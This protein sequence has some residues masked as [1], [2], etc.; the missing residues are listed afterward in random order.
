MEQDDII[1]LIQKIDSR[2]RRIEMLITGDKDF[3]I[4]GLVER[5]ESCEKVS[6]EYKKDKA[7]VIGG[8]AAIGA[9]G[10]GVMAWLHKIFW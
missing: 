2:T 6:D 4:T 10:G 3:R 1:A 7:K 5:I 9:A 8:A